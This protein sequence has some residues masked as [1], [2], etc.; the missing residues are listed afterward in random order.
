MRKV[1]LTL[2]A[3]S[4]LAGC[5]GSTFDSGP[6]L[7]NLQELSVD[8]DSIVLEPQV[9]FTVD[10]QQT[11]ESYRQLV[12]LAG[13]LGNGSE[14][15]KLAD[16]ELEAGIDQQANEESSEDDPGKFNLSE[17][18]VIY[19]QY[20]DRFGENPDSDLVYYQLSR[21]YSH[22]GDIER[23]IDTLDTIAGQYPNSVHIDEV[24]FRRGEY[25]FAINNY[26]LAEDA[27]SSVVYETPDSTYYEKSLYKFGWAMFKQ[28]RYRGALNQFVQL[29]DRYAERGDIDEIQINPSLNRGEQELLQDV[30][31]VVSLCFDYEESDI[32]VAAYFQQ[33]GSRS[34]E[35]LITDSLGNFYSEKE[36]FLESANLYLDFGKDYPLSRHR[37]T[38]HQ[39]AIQTFQETG[40]GDRV[41]EQKENFVNAYDVGSP[42]WQAQKTED[43]SKVGG[44]LQGHF[45]DIA[46][47]HHAEARANKKPA[48]YTNASNWYRRYLKSFPSEKSSSRVNFLLAESLSENNQTDQAIIE[49]EKTAYQYPQHNESAEAGYA[50]LLGYDKKLSAQSSPPAS[51]Q[52]QRYQSAKRFVDRFT[53]DQR[54]PEIQ[55]QVAAFAYKS[56]DHRTTIQYARP[57]ANEKSFTTQQRL[58]AS[59][60]V[61]DS[62][63]SLGNY[64]S[65]EEAY[66]VVLARL[67]QRDK[68]LPALREQVA[69]SIYKQAE[70]AREEQ[71]YADAASLFLRV[72]STVPESEI[73]ETADYDAA[74]AW[75]DN[76]S[77][78]N[79]IQSLEQFRKRYPNNKK[80]RIPVLEKLAYAH[81][82]LGNNQGAGREML[83]L[84]RLL[85][86]GDRKRDLTKT[87][88]V[89]FEKAGNTD[90]AITIYE[91]YVGNYPNPLA[92]SME[93]RHKIVEHYREKREPAKVRQWL[94]AIVSAEEKAKGSSNGRARFLAASARMELARPA[95]ARYHRMKLTVPLKKSLAGKKKLLEQLQTSYRAAIAYQIGEITT[96]ATY[97]LGEL[98]HEF[99]NALL[100]SERP[101]E[102]DELALEEYDLLLEEQAYPFEEKAIEIH[103]NN[104]SLIPTGDFDDGKQKSLAVLGE[105]MPFRYA[106]E[107]SVA[108]YVE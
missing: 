88:A 6:T 69:A 108:A 15:R 98:Y 31:R 50:A 4:T 74:N 49:F 1:I 90:Q 54:R 30:L 8:I 29:L 42:Y 41:L 95:L 21:A 96:E 9:S 80:W 76:K 18:I 103:L 53:S 51:L 105:L 71:R 5:A 99:A 34:F 14:L 61:A 92:E 104:F 13:K 101:K 45:L 68:R 23:S 87:A 63:F 12:E 60:L 81:D 83:A 91:G 52:E 44:M 64:G 59:L 16:L 62:E 84:A 22:V 25:Y 48:S 86:A 38:F 20:L 11:I 107:E 40:Y 56:E 65:A 100:D 7:Q 70:A 33:S 67:P 19:E 93:L 36:L 85:P 55:L 27:Y 77:W 3:T 2:L 46:S 32:T 75:L 28:N 24:Q 17:A 66:N 106:R 58:Q 35:P 82:Q 73:R 102:L 57:L 72:G 79:A 47:Y 94:T 39:K 43:Q 10:P 97:Q 78:D 89:A 26:A 37:P